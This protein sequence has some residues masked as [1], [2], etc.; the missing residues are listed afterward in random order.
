[1]DKSELLNELVEKVRQGEISHE[2]IRSRL[3][4]SISSSNQSSLTGESSKVIKGF[5]AFSINKILYFL[6][7]AIAIIGL[8]VFFAQVWEDIGSVGRIFVT[9]GIGLLLAILGSLLLKSKP[10]ENLGAVFHFM[11]GL[12]IPGGALVILNE[13]KFDVIPPEWFSLTFG[14]I[15][16]F[17]LLLNYVHKNAVLSLFAI[18]NGT[19]FIYSCVE[20]F[21][22]SYDYYG[23]VYTYLTTLIGVSYLLLAYDFK[24]SSNEKLV[25]GLYFF[26]SVCFLGSTF[27]LMLDNNYWELPYFLIVFGGIALSAYLRSRIVLVLST[28][29]LIIHLSYITDKYFA[30]SL[31]WPLSLVILGF[32]FIG[33]GYISVNIN[34]KYI[35]E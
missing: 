33:L 31:G 32:V 23:N 4:Y 26:G 16:V 14:I 8:F 21:Y 6:G 12:L 30:D 15:F 3:N 34:K 5:S 17:Y 29:F 24:G 9:F 19:A 13:L 25:G 1:M 10:A 11:A 22:K 7:V 20:V 18:V 35:A 2:E 28:L 27:S